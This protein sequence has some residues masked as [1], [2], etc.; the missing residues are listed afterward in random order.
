MTLAAVGTAGLRVAP[1]VGL[2]VVELTVPGPYHQ[3]LNLF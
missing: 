1:D 2:Q 3:R